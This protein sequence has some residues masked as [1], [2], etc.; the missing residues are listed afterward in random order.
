MV[1][2]IAI[3][4][5]VN[6]Y[7]G[8]TTSGTKTAACGVYRTFCLRLLRCNC[9]S[10]VLDGKKKRTRLLMGGVVSRRQGVIPFHRPFSSFPLANVSRARLP[11]SY[12]YYIGCI[13]SLDQLLGESGKHVSVVF[14][15]FCLPPTRILVPPLLSHHRS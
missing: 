2:D 13:Q 15:S 7:A 10:R 3:P 5:H 8:C 12:S 1:R 4:V 9:S 6:V 14:A 11:T